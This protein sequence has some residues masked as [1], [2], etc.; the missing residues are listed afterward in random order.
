MTIDNGQV[1]QAALLAM[2]RGEARLFRPGSAEA[3]AA[4][5]VT[6]SVAGKALAAERFETMRVKN[7][8]TLLIVRR[9]AKNQ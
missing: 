3:V 7:D 6:A 8:P 4:A 2:R 9:V 5:Q 1:T